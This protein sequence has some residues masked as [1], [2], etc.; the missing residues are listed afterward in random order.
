MKKL[1]ILSAMMAGTILFTAG[2]GTSSG[3]QNA[4]DSA[5]ASSGEKKT[6]PVIVSSTT[7]EYWQ[8]VNQGA[9]KA[10]EEL[11][12]NVEFKGPATETDISAQ[13]GIVEDAIN[14]KAAA[15][16]IAPGDA[17]AL[18]PSVEKAVAAGI[19]VVTIDSGVDSDKPISYIATDNEAAAALAAKHMAE[20]IGKKGKVAIVNF[21]AGNTTG[22]AREKGFKDEMKKYPDIEIVNTFYSGGDKAKS[23]AITQ[24]LLTSNPDIAG[25]FGTNESCAVGIAMAVK[26]KGMQ[27]KVKVIGFDSSKDEIQFLEQ[28]I[29]QAIVV[30]NP[31]KM[32]Y[33][34]VKNALEVVNGGTPEAKVD[35][36]ATLITKDNMD[37]P[38]NQM[39]LYPFGK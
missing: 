8:T 30:Q 14:Q 7:H 22:M 11:G 31:F 2:C 6:I 15:I 18:V 29:M 17:K 39:L 16:V 1:T 33:L 4:G 13:V 23:L 3:T 9:K 35:T 12:V 32:G 5:S 38:E 19:P 10:G 34:G 20:L 21:T 37:E 27:D 24:D 26:E 25:I 28:G 36:G